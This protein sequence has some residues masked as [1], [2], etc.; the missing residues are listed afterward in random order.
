MNCKISYF[1][2][3]KPLKFHFGKPKW[4]KNPQILTQWPASKQCAFHKKVENP[5]RARKNNEF[6][7]QCFLKG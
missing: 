3:K 2:F 5:F 1:D 4:Q 7:R 6:D